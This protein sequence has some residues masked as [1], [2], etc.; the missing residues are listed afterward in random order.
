MNRNILQDIKPLTSSGK[1]GVITELKSREEYVAPQSVPGN[2]QIP[3]RRP[4]NEY[5]SHQDDHTPKSRKGIW[6]VTILALV[7]LFIAVSFVFKG[8][9]VLVTPKSQHVNITDTFTAKSSGGDSDLVF[10]V[11]EIDEEVSREI[12]T[13]ETK[14][15]SKKATGK[16]TLY[17]KSSSPQ[18]LKIDTRLETKDGKIFKTDKALTIPAGKTVS[19]KV[20][21]GQIEVTV[22]ADAPGE[23]YNIPPSDFVI[24]GFKGTTRA[25]QFSGKST[26]AMQGGFKGMEANIGEEERTKLTE[27]LREE[28]K[29]SLMTKAVAQVPAEF[30]YYDD[31]VFFNPSSTLLVTKVDGKV[32][33]S[34]SGT[35]SIILFDEGALTRYLAKENITD[36][37]SSDIVL[38]GLKSMKFSLKSKDTISPK[39]AKDFSFTFSGEGDFVWSVDTDALK[40]ALV[41]K[42]KRE[43]TSLLSS[44]KSV[45][46]AEVSLNPL[47]MTSF[48]VDKND[49]VVK[50]KPIGSENTQ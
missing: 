37:D 49:I 47:W 22:T 41:G 24:F 30:V 29:T 9:T 18:A 5:E 28:L 46:S 44:F 10:D 26:A 14:E 19:G 12:E 35:L 7:G 42:K 15:V 17:N 8:A 4:S 16:V 33:A 6:I 39:E 21:P 11:V 1:R 13:T 32:N 2:S 36:Y 31:G 40:E 50:L 43:F 34:L 45:E 23:E 48:P 25:S 20:T 3:P 38:Q 27:A